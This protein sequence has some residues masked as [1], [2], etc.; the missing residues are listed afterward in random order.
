MVIQSDNQAEGQASPGAGQDGVFRLGD[1]LVNTATRE[2]RRGERVERLEPRVMQVLE[3]LAARSGTVVSRRDLESHVWSGMIVT[4]DAVT[5]TVIKLRR[6]LGD[7]ARQPR[8]IETIAKSG[9]RLVAPVEPV[10]AAAA[11]T[12]ALT[13]TETHAGPGGEFEPVG[14]GEQTDRV[15]TERARRSPRQFPRRRLAVLTAALLA[16]AV[17]AWTEWRVWINPPPPTVADAAVVVA[18]LPFENLSGDPAQDYFADGVT[19]DLITDLSRLSALQVVARNS[20][21][22]YRGSAES[23]TAIGRALGA[24]YVVK[25]SVQRAGGRLR[26]NVNLTDTR[27]GRNRWGERYDRGLAD[28]FAVQDEIAARVVSALQLE[29]AAGDRSRLARRYVAGIEAYDE[30]LRGLDLLGRRASADNAQARVH[31][32]RAIDLD[33]GFA[34]AYA[35]L[36]MTHALQA[37]YAHGPQVAMALEEAGEIARAGLA[38]DDT[39]PQLHYAMALVEM[40]RGELS[41][42]AESVARAIELRPS[43]ADGY[44]LMAWI[45]HFAGRPEE[46][47]AAMRR[48]IALNPHVTALYR[49]VEAALHYELGE[50]DKARSLLEQAVAVNPEQFLARL[51]LAAVYAASGELDNARWQVDE[52]R[53]VDADFRL[54]LAHGFPIRDPRYRDRFVADLAL[55]GLPAE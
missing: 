36:A 28:I 13:P 52:I 42:A 38:I 21:L 9:Y 14:A 2:L 27:G 4:D 41:A 10:P 18:V 20:V 44:G 26:V 33:P 40:Y 45:L 12:A 25:G 6:A 43:Y 53:A 22:A 29:L 8:Y 11:G 3:F 16:V 54:D 5:N 1:W 17:V 15:D 24:D 55:A 51:Y 7:K 30:L 49:T 32:A 31:F 47:M 50:L 35:G 34:R 19:Q 39:Q 37:V 46:G 23:E 48:A